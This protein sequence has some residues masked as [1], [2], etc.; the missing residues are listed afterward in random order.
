[1]KYDI[2]NRADIE[3]LIGAFYQKLL[4][5]PIVGPIFTDVAQIDLVAHLPILC[6]FWENILFHVA[7][8]KGN[9]MELHLELH[10]KYPLSQMH[11]DRWLDSFNETVDN[12]FEGD[13][14]TL[15]KTRAHSI[16]L[17]IQMKIERRDKKNR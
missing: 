6:D 17:L 13:R 12:Y 14:A 10:D 11:F 15:A 9:T 7:K 5:D 3:M 8:Y 1:M 16:A 4:V 2:Q